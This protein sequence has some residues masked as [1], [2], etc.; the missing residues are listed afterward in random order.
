[1]KTN[2][3]GAAAAAIVAVSVVVL[4]GCSSGNATEP[5]S[6]DR[7]D[8]AENS[9]TAILAMP[10]IDDA[11]G[12]VI[13]GE[14]VA[15]AELLAAARDTSVNWV[16]SSGSE[17]A[18]LTAARFEA[19]TGVKIEVSRLAATKLNERLLSEAGVGRLTNDVVTIGDPVFAEGLAEQG[20][21]VPYTTIPA[22]QTLRNT[23]NVVWADGAYYTAYNTV[24][25]IAY[26]N[27]AV[28]SEDA[29][30]SWDDLLDPK[31]NGQLGIVSAGAGGAAQGLAAFADHVLGD[32]YRE[33]FAAQKPRIFDV[34]SVAIEA[35]ARG[36]IQAAPAV[37]NTAFAAAQAGAPITIV[38]PAEGVSGTFNMQG[39]TAK[40]E[41][42]PAAQLFMNWTWSQSGQQFAEAQGFVSA[43]TDTEQ[44]PTGDYQLPRASDDTFWVYTPEA[45]QQD[46]A[47]VVRRWNQA[48]GISG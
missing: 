20:V 33:D 32:D 19:E 42:N 36:E 47:E 5:G 23:E 43:R 1:M 37:V 34:T 13:G 31:W 21:F 40:G 35:L 4:S 24:S 18:E 17:S 29:P 14:E 22:Y 12:L 28:A 9:T 27:L 26:N 10:D 45:A 41:G 39:L 2:S 3:Y 15:D 44:V 16:T 8:T 11:D 6:S 48:F 7:P 46:G 30:S 25:G 38:V